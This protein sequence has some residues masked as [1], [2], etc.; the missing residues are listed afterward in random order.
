MSGSAY[1]H[2]SAPDEQR[3][4]ARMNDLINA[5]LLRELRLEGGERILDLGC[6]L[7]QLT[8]AMAR[9]AGA[10]GRVI[11]IERDPRQIEEAKR[12]QEQAGDPTR[13]EL[14]EGDALDLPLE[15]EEWASFDLV[16]TRFLLEH[17]QDPLRAVRGMV[18]A[19]RPGGRIVLADDDHP[20]LRP[21]PEIPGF[22]PLWSAYQEA[23][24]RLGNDPE[25]GR[26]LVALLH[27][28][29]AQPR[30]NTWG[31]FGACAGSDDW[32]AMVENLLGVLRTG[33]VT[34]EE[35][36]LLAPEAFDH[37]MREIAAWAERPDAAL[38]YAFSVAEGVRPG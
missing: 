23:F 6:G 10:A 27:E 24:R 15:D 8:R 26:R 29:G 37:G 14:R 36:R 7:A 34:I 16:V 12:L 2:G 20:L 22:A 32:A 31:F 30:R 11:G 3:R 13:I 17:L 18:R 5:P 33:R 35:H 9:Q 19:A 38:W 25:I 21:W 28:A 1:L 4:L